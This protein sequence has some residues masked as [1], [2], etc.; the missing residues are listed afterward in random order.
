MIFKIDFFIKFKFLTFLEFINIV[1]Y[2]TALD[3]A[4][5]INYPEIVELLTKTMNQIIMTVQTSMQKSEGVIS[6][7]LDT[8]EKIHQLE[9]INEQ[10]KSKNLQLESNI[11]QLTDKMAQ[12]ESDNS[13]LESSNKQLTDKVNKLQQEHDEQMRQV[14]EQMNQMK[15]MIE[16]LMKKNSES[17]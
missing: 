3:Y 5:E 11:E 16:M 6:I 9:S 4:K 14:N 1:I 17:A 2:K 10:L 12:L 13:Q 15:M 7:S 8:E